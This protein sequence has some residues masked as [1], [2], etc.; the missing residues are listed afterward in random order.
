MQISVIYSGASNIKFN[1]ANLIKTM[2]IRE[3]MY[4]PKAELGDEGV[5]CYK[6]NT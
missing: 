2:S 1:A 6:C 5:H 4:V 3:K